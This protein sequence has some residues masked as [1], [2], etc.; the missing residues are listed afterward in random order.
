ML[1]LYI[2]FYLPVFLAFADVFRYH[3]SCFRPIQIDFFR[4]SEEMVKNHNVFVPL[5]LMTPKNT[6][7]V[8]T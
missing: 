2:S 5:K 1:S 7:Y 4:I 6:E 8:L 3:L